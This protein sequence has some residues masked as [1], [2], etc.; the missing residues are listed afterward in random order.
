MFLSTG[1]IIV[2]AT[3]EAGGAPSVFQKASQV[4]MT[5]ERMTLCLQLRNWLFPRSLSLWEL[6]NFQNTVCWCP[7]AKL[8]PGEQLKSIKIT[9]WMALLQTY[10]TEFQTAAIT[11]QFPWIFPNKFHNVLSCPAF[12]HHLKSSRFRGYWKGRLA[13]YVGWQRAVCKI[14]TPDTFSSH[15][16]QLCFPNPLA[17]EEA[18]NLSWFWV[19]AFAELCI[20]R[21][22]N[23]KL[24]SNNNI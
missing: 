15:A 20:S 9:H 24:I 7:R 1:Y 12:P 5:T 4:T 22:G 14:S 17:L 19:P 18:K 3:M 21:S 2:V 10:W 23:W 16:M 13:K 11:E 8:S 6:N